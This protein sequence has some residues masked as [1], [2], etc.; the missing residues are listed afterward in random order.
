MYRWQFT[1]RRPPISPHLPDFTL[2]DGDT[3]NFGTVSLKC[4]ILPA[5]HRAAS[6]FLPASTSSPEILFFR[7]VPVIPGTL[8]P[9]SRLL[10]VLRKS[11]LFSPMIQGFTPVTAVILP[12]VKR[13]RNSPPFP[14]DRMLPIFAV[15]CSGDMLN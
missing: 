15:T 14:V 10:T 11:S 8:L 2:K 3:L 4:C 7:E 6:A 12:W 13:N 1:L 5:I 9:L